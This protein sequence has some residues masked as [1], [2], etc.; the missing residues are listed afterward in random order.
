GTTSR[1]TTS[2]ATMTFGLNL[3]SDIFLFYHEVSLCITL[4]PHFFRGNHGARNG[5]LQLF[6]LR[7]AYN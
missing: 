3:L 5:H 1:A 6:G 7:F 4:V 2:R